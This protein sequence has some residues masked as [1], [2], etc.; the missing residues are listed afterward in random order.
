MLPAAHRLTDPAGFRSATRRG[1]RAA[2]R[3]LVAHYETGSDP[4]E[5]GFVVGKQV[6]GAVVRN[7]VRRRLRHA[8]RELLVV[9][10]LP[11]AGRLV[12]RA[13]P[14]SAGATYG[15]LSSDLARCAERAC[16]P[17]A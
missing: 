17:A 10:A 4:L 1:R 16:A 3:T 12:V 11:D 13:L 15:E 8:T 9:G 2:A 6:G 5:A 14:A 7:R